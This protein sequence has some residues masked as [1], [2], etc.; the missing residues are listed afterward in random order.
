M[1]AMGGIIDV[2]Q[3]GGLRKIL[4]WTFL[5]F[6]AGSLALAGVPFLSGFFSKD[7][8]IHH[9]LNVNPL[10]GGIGLLT[11]VLTAFYTFRMVFLA[12]FGK[13]RV[14]TGVHPHES[15]GWMLVPLVVLSLGAIGA[16]YVGVGGQPFHEFL[17]P[18]FEQTF[19][20]NHPIAGHEA[21]AAHPGFWAHYGL[22]ILTGG[23]AIIAII[24]AYV[25]Y[26]TKPWIPG[27]VRTSAPEAYDTLWNKYH[28]DELYDLGVVEPA[29]KTGRACVGLDDYFI[30]GLIWFVTAVPRG[31]AYLLR[32][33]Q[34][35]VMQGYALTM[36][37]GLAIIVLWVLWP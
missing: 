13:E 2:R 8:I 35:G 32:G 16:G 25:F 18:V 22:M 21:A 12:F 17:S 27:L 23:L 28:V 3:F 5:T 31:L 11:A 26:V 24:V 30:D 9:A 15:G 37:A 33:L 36:V 29:R 6:V 4:P 14:P 1:H 19:V 10:L 7:E 34:G 20:A